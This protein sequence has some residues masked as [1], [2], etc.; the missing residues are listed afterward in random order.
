MERSMERSMECPTWY[1]FEELLPQAR[2]EHFALDE[3]KQE[4]ER[5]AL[6]RGWTSIFSNFSAHADG[7]RRGLDRVG[8]AS[9]GEVSPCGGVFRVP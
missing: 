3:Q 9:V 4:P 1:T 7:E 8:R 5:L 2:L 6:G